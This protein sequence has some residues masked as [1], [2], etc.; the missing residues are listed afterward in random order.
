MKSGRS[1]RIIRFSAHPNC[2]L[3][4]THGGLLSTT[5]A[6]HTATPILGIPVFADQFAN[7]QQAVN[8][9][10]ARKVTLSFHMVPELKE[11]INEMI[12]NPK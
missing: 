1:V 9:G 5:E 2:I 11:A 8:R 10:F 12:S 6:V 3:F 7:V 4:I